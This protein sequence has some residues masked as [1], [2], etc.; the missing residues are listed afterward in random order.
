[1]KI[2]AKSIEMFAI[3]RKVVKLSRLDNDRLYLIPE[4]NKL[5]I[6]AGN[7]SVTIA[8]MDM[9]A[10]ISG[11]DIRPFWIPAQKLTAFLRIV[12]GENNIEINVRKKA[13]INCIGQKMLLPVEFDD[14]SVVKLF[15]KPS[16]DFYLSKDQVK[17]F[18][19]ASNLASR[20]PG[21]NF[22]GV[23]FHIQSE[24]IRVISTDGYGVLMAWDTMKG[25]ENMQAL[26][27]A[28][29]VGL[30]GE[31][32]ES[33]IG[34]CL[35]GSRISFVNEDLFISAARVSGVETFPTS[36]I[37]KYLSSKTYAPCMIDTDDL[38]NKLS[39]CS[40]ITFQGKNKSMQV[41]RIEF[42]YDSDGFEISSNE[43]GGMMRFEVLATKLP[44]I[45]KSIQFIL[46]SKF[47]QGAINILSKLENSPS[48]QIG[49]CGA[50]KNWATFQGN[51]SNMIFG[52]SKIIK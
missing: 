17:M 23:L 31:I 39:A 28:I 1:M 27:P 36:T 51:N 7:H 38:K 32:I 10:D 8:R 13:S 3:V 25:A 11:K 30:M 46:D 15:N 41:A 50:Y 49:E 40:M 47:V 21:S 37:V 16:I 42:E 12:S 19:L 18:S 35:T 45:D 20:D 24:T 29:A 48:I 5:G 52:F 14:Y 2:I 43:E 33:K 26:V 34:V 4:E 22:S 9:S 44:P 6:C